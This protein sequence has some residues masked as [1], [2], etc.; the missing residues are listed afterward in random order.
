MILFQ[1]Q[2]EEHQQLA[3]HYRELAAKREALAAGLLTVQQQA[4]SDLSSLKQLVGKCK[5]VAP[6]AIAT[7]KTAVLNLFSDG[8]GGNDDGNQ[9]TEPTPNP[10]DEKD[11]LI[12]LNGETG[13]YLLSDGSTSVED[14]D[15]EQLKSSTLTYTQTIKNRCSACWGYEVKSKADIKAGFVNRTHLSFMGVVNLERTGR[16]FYETVENYLDRLYYNGQSCE[17]ASPFA[18]P[19]SFDDTLYPSVLNAGS[20]FWHGA[21]WSL[22]TVLEHL[23]GQEYRCQIDG[24]V[25]E[26]GLERHHLHYVPTQ[27]EGQ[28][29]DIDA[30]PLTGQHCQLTCYWENDWQ[31]EVLNGQAWEI[32]SP[33]CC[34]LSDAPQHNKNKSTTEAGDMAYIE[35]VVHAQNKAIAYQRKHDGEII[36][37]YVGFRTKAI[38]QSWMH[39]IEAVTDR[40]ELR[41]AL[42][43]QGFKWELKI[44]GMGMKQLERLVNEPID[45]AYR[46]EVNTAVPPTYK[47][48]PIPQPVNPD[49]V[50]KGDIVTQL[51]TPS[52]SYRVEQV[53]PN[54]ILDCTNLTT[55]DRLGIRP[56]AV[57]LVQKAEHP[58]LIACILEVGDIVEV[59]EPPLKGEV[60]TVTQFN[61]YNELPL[62]V[63]TPG[64]EFS[65]KRQELKFISRPERKEPEIQVPSLFAA[66]PYSKSFVGC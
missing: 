50:G 20:R 5:E 29:C 34:L 64:G 65:F 25:G 49:E 51:L 31:L 10:D 14:G 21:T 1:S 58:D 60:G 59:L 11:E 19:A 61:R 66:S 38:A 55:G 63:R 53:M 4:D 45:K 41:Q 42:R 35:L 28:H 47:P 32:A 43:M 46:T 24:A 52:H 3:E 40:V 17:W 62:M 22:G 26:V 6:S 37:V 36:C 7:L 2:I 23:E 13:D 48:Q 33:L 16:E 27:L 57:T 39:F 8:D 9:P 18:S 15:E 12:C 56:G 30:A 44:K 54:G